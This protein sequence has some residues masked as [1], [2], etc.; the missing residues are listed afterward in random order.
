[1]EE[2]NR[3][4]PQ[5]YVSDPMMNMGGPEKRRGMAIASLVL[6]VL[7]L[8]CCCIGIG[9]IPAIVGAVLGLIAL[10]T[11]EGKARVMGGIG[12]ALSAIG[13]LISLYIIVS[14][15]MAI[16]W[17]NFTWENFSTFQ[18]IDPDN[19][20]QMR[21]WLQQFFNVDISSSSYYSYYY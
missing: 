3:Y 18:Y 20:E 19:E 13:L 4:E 7:S 17:E 9:L 21:Q 16:R 14:L 1:M 5:Q 8:L 15:L 10:I 2:E 12:L 6:G 11:G